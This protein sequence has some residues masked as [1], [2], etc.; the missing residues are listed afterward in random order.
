M[1]GHS[2]WST[3]KRKKGAVDAARGKLFTRLA[4][5]IQVAARNGADP[6]ANFTLRLAIERARAENMPKENIERAI[7]RGAG[8]DKDYTDNI[9]TVIYE[10]YGPHGVAILVEC[11]TDNRNRTISEVRRTFTKGNGSLGEPGSVAWQFTEKGYLLFS[12]VNEDG[13]PISLDPDEL[14]MAA[15]ESGAE[16]VEI[17]EDAVEVYTERTNFAQVSQALEERGYRASQAELIMKPNNTI[18]LSPE[19][20]ASVLNLVEALEE[21]DDVNKVYHNLALTEE[22]VAQFA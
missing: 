11:L 12:R 22:M 14:F 4:R 6:A 9:E 3:I 18:E 10:G 2:K 20:A 13:Q 1:S 19:E 15:I 7:R 21:L 8:L 17:S 16:D 5:E